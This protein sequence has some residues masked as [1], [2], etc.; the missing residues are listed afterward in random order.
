MVFVAVNFESSS[1]NSFIIASVNHDLMCPSLH[2]VIL[3]SV[4]FFQA[5]IG[6]RKRGSYTTCVRCAPTLVISTIDKLTI[7][8]MNEVSRLIFDGLLKFNLKG[9]ERRDLLYFL[10]DRIDP[11]NMAFHV[12]GP[13]ASQSHPHT[14]KCILGLPC[15]GK[16]ALMGATERQHKKNKVLQK[17]SP[18][19]APTA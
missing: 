13:G 14:M 16:D 6:G 18:P 9:L 1:S 10:M 19:G 15:G 17:R 5:T 12:D 4:L 3:T 8:Q 7:D 2:T 11:N